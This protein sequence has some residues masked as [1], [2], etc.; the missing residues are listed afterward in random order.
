VALRLDHLLFARLLS[1]LA[2]LARSDATKDVEIPVLRHEVA[3][4]PAAA[5]ELGIPVANDSAAFSASIGATPR[6]Y[7]ANSDL[8]TN[9]HRPHPALGQAAPLRPLPQRTTTENHTD[10]RARLGGLLHEYQQVA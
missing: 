1:W 8:T 10:R 7:F 3:R 5:G 9:G 4:A 2:L 6:P